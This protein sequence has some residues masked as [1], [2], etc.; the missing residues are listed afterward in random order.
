MVVP[1]RAKAI[2]AA[3]AEAGSG[4]TVL[5]AGKGHEVYQEAGGVRKEFSDIKV[6]REAIHSMGKGS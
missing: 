5:I 2:Y 3:M 4:D 6:A 1:D